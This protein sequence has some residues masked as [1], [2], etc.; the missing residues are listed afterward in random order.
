MGKTTLQDRGMFLNLKYINDIDNTMYPPHIKMRLGRPQ[1]VHY[2]KLSEGADADKI[3]RFLLENNDTDPD[4]KYARYTK[5]DLIPF[6]DIH[7]TFD[8]SG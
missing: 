8:L 7:H 4:K 6:K 3:G 2:V 1:S 5:I